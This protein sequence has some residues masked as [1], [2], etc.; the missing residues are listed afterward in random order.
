VIAMSFDE[1]RPTAGGRPIAGGSEPRAMAGPEQ[2]EEILGVT[3]R[4]SMAEVI[5]AGP[6]EPLKSQDAIKTYRYLR[7]GLIG[8]VVLLAVSIAIERSKVDCWQTSISAYY[9]TPVRAIFVGTMIAVGLSLIVYKGRSNVEDGCLNF[10]GMLAPA[11][12]VAPTTDVGRC[13][14]VAPSPLPVNDDGSLADWVVTNIDNNIYALLIAGGIGLGVAAIIAMA[15]NRSVRAPIDVGERGTRVS[16]AVTAL[17]LL[18]GWWLIQNWDDF[19]TRAHGFAAVLMFV[20]LIGAIVAKAIEHWDEREKVWFWVYAAVA[21][22][23]VLG[24]ILIPTTRVF[25][26]HTVFALEA[27]EIAFFAF[28]WIVQTVE[29]WNEKVIGTVPVQADAGFGQVHGRE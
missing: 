26:D 12:A 11:V 15:V 18:L 21:A 27:Y 17:V 6:A 13:W 24:G 16:L 7:I 3:N 25:D 19:N 2:P 8:A 22:L 23:M 1:D 10:A 5:A 29:N 9:Y 14:S 4:R 28:Y 20:F